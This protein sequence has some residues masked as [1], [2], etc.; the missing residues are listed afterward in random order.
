MAGPQHRF[1]T[2]ATAKTAPTFNLGSGETMCP[3]LTTAIEKEPVKQ[4]AH[5]IYG[6][7]QPQNAVPARQLQ[8]PTFTQEFSMLE[9]AAACPVWWTINLW[10]LETLRNITANGAT[11]LPP[12]SVS[13]LGAQGTQ[14]SRLKARITYEN[15]TP[16]RIDVDIGTGSCLSL[17]ANSVRIA[18]L[19][20]NT[21]RLSG[22]TGVDLGP[23]NI[24]DSRASTSCYASE[25]PVGQRSATYTQYEVMEPDEGS[26]DIPVPPGAK[27][28]S[29]YYD[30]Q[31]A[32]TALEW[33]QST[34]PVTATPVGRLDVGPPDFITEATVPQNCDTLRI[35]TEAGGTDR[36]FNIIW[37]LRF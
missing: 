15:V 14:F 1:S 11:T 9:A 37:H 31:S 3:P 33:R 20:P 16:Y 35:P 23:G 17:L 32:A 22:V 4:M 28:I 18:L 6:L 13:Q 30:P 19:L 25:S 7:W 21:F 34:V 29:V 12:L 27:F 36:G 26:R 5:Q 24:V 10:A 2:I 8:T